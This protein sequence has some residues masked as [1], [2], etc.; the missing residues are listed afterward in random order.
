MFPI[1]LFKNNGSLI[2]QSICLF[3]CFSLFACSS[4]EQYSDNYLADE[5]NSEHFITENYNDNGYTRGFVNENFSHTQFTPTNGNSI[6]KPLPSDHHLMM[7]LLNRPMTADQAMMLAF[8]KER[9]SYH[10]PFSNDGVEI[11]GERYPDEPST[12]S[13]HAYAHLISQDINAVTIS[14]PQ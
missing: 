7:S 11:K 2:K 3:F 9:E 4:T 8:A 14:A 6:K 12:R 5:Y 13:R 1:H 10:S